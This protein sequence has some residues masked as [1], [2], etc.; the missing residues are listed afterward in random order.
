MSDIEALRKIKTLKM[1]N[2]KPAAEFWK[3]VG[4][5]KP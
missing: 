4:V 2:G 3:E 5:G 1:I